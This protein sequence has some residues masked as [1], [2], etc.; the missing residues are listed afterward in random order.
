LNAQRRKDVIKIDT[1]KRAG[2]RDDGPQSIQAI[3]STAWDRE[4]GVEWINNYP[5]TSSDLPNA[6]GN[7]W[8]FYNKL[9]SYGGACS[10]GHCFIYGNTSAYEE[11]F[12]R[13]DRGGKNNYYVDDVDIVFYEG[14]GWPGGFTFKTPWGHGTHDDSYLSI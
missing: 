12:K 4:I 10:V 2:D 6:A 7:A 1:S 11:D 5:G 14:H 9:R 3:A 8:G 13:H